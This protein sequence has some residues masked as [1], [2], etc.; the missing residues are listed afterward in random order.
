MAHDEHF[1]ERLK[2][3]QGAQV[4]LALE[5]Y[6]DSA[7][8]RSILKYAQVGEHVER[9][10]VALSKNSDGPHVIVARDGGFVTCLGEGMAFGD[11]PVVCAT[12]RCPAEPRRDH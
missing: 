12:P 3:I 8:V 2:R 5:L 6:Y 11:L 1:L 4:D 9:I 7:L 10:A